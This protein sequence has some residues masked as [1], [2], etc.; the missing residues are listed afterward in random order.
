MLVPSF[1]LV[2]FVSYCLDSPVGKVRRRRRS[3]VGYTET[4]VL[5]STIDSFHMKGTPRYVK[6]RGFYSAVDRNLE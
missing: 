5:A 2:R 6:R 4:S 1:D 3:P